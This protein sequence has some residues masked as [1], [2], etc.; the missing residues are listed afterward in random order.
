MEQPRTEPWM[1]PRVE[2]AVACATLKGGRAD[3]LVEKATEVRADWLVEK[4][5]EVRT[6]GGTI[7]PPC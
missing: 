6:A 5:A 2:L 3:W 1:G 4:G 7:Q